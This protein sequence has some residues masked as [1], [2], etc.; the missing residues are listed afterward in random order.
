MDTLRTGQAEVVG[1]SEQGQLDSSG[2]SS[3]AEETDDE[4]KSDAPELREL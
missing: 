2:E 3:E 4:Y 1:S